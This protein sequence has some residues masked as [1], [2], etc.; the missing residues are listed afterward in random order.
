MLGYASML[1]NKLHVVLG[2]ALVHSMP[3]YF[4]IIFPPS[5]TTTILC[6]DMLLCSPT[7]CSWSGNITKWWIKYA[8]K[9]HETKS[10]VFSWCLFENIMGFTLNCWLGPLNFLS[11]GSDFNLFVWF[12]EEPR[13]LDSFGNL[14][15]FFVPTK[16]QK[17]C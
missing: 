9:T 1:F 7:Q 10:N 5:L 16:A 15:L 17:V 4:S 14:A 6:W 11:S 2:W 8:L 13:A 12:V 3:I